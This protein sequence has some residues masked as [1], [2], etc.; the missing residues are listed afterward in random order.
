MER[1]RSTHI[2]WN[3]KQLCTH[4]F[5][6]PEPMYTYMHTFRIAGAKTLTTMQKRLLPKRLKGKRV[7]R[8]V[9]RMRE[10]ARLPEGRGAAKE[11]MRVLTAKVTMMEA[12]G[13]L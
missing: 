13:R 5:T 3:M 8:G 7:A 1:G 4:S 10:R 2:T 9:G 11:R 12:T 6:Y